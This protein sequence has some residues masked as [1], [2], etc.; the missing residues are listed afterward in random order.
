MKKQGF[1]QTHVLYKKLYI[2][3]LSGSQP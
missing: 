3:Q 1:I 2:K